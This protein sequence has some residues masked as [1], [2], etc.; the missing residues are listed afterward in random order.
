MER[1]LLQ[2]AKK[3]TLK[4]IV[5]LLIDAVGLVSNLIPVHIEMNIKR[6]SIFGNPFQDSSV[7]THRDSPRVID[8]LD[9]FTRAK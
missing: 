9:D 5:L 4:L 1:E 2:K 8:D 6:D 3:P 7:A